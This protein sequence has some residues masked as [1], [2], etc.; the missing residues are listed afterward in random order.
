MGET[1][2]QRPRAGVDTARSLRGFDSRSQQALGFGNFTFRGEDLGE[3]CARGWII[4]CR[5]EYSLVFSLRLVPITASPGDLGEV[6][7][8]PKAVPARRK[9]STVKGFGLGPI[10]APDK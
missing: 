5:A 6:R 4:G 1:Q 7:P 9:R 2:S 10:A 3:S 8:Q